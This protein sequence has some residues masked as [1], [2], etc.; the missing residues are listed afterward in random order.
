[1]PGGIGGER[2]AA[3][4]D[5]EDAYGEVTHRGQSD[6]RGRGASYGLRQAKPSSIGAGTSHL[7]V[8]M[9]TDL[10]QPR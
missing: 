2:R 10:N 8:M 4:D 3:G 1:V 6:R 5:E 9:P 7:S